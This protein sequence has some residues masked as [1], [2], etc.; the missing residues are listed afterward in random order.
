MPKIYDLS[1]LIVTYKTRELVLKCIQ[2]SI[3]SC[4]KAGLTNYQIIVVDN[5]SNDGTVEEITQRYPMV[6][7]IASA[8]NLGPARGYN[9]ALRVALPQSK[10]VML[11]NSDIV[12]WEDTVTHM[13]SCLETHEDVSGVCGQLFFPNGQRQRIRTNILDIKRADYSK[14][15]RV[16][17]VGTGFNMIRWQAYEQV[18]LYDE[19]YYFYN[20]DLDWAERARRLKLKFILVPEAKVY[21][22]L[23]QGSK[24]NYSAIIKELYKSNLYFFKKFYNPIIVSIAYGAIRLENWLAIRKL[25]KE[26]KDSNTTEER[27]IEIAKSLD[28]LNEAKQELIR[29]RKTGVF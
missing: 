13:Y 12:L 3:E 11:L 8:D 24:Q 16:T 7:L 21:H 19:N 27:K 26:A 6:K 28:V 9:K 22:H 5:A 10:Y 1:I 17:F 20:E 23:S 2:S 15:F 25:I 18:G 29:Y 14:P 4:Q